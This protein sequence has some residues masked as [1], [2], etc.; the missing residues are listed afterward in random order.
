VVKICCSFVT[1][2]KRV[3]VS[4]RSAFSPSV[5]VIG[6]SSSPRRIWTTSGRSAMNCSSW[7]ACS[8][9]RAAT[10]AAMSGRDRRDGGTAAKAI[11]CPF[12]ESW[13]GKAVASVAR[14]AATRVEVKRI[15]SIRAGDR[16]GGRGAELVGWGRATRGRSVQWTKV[17]SLTDVDTLVRLR[18]QGVSSPASV[19]IERARAASA[20]SVESALR[21]TTPRGLI[22]RRRSP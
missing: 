3:P 1:S 22:T 19:L 10:A 20:E 5:M 14:H 4:V 2:I 8:S 16:L 21:T 13:S 17:A 6:S 15:A 18:D 7:T 9:G 11:C 12:G